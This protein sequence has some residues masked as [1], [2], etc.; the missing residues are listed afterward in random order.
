M[1]QFFG[2]PSLYLRKKQW[3]FYGMSGI[4]FCFLLLFLVFLPQL[5]AFL[6]KGIIG[7]VI[8]ILIIKIVPD[9][10]ENLS[11]KFRLRG[12]NFY[13]G[14]RGEE[15]VEKE[16]NK[17][18]S[19]YLI[20]RNVKLKKGDCDFV[21]VGPPGVFAIEVKDYKYATISFDGHDLT[22]N[23]KNKKSEIHQSKREAANIQNFL[24]TI[25][26]YVEPIVVFSEPMNLHFYFNKQNGA[27]VIGKTALI[28]L[29]TQ[30]PN[31]LTIDQINKIK[32]ILDKKIIL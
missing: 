12:D 5:A 10:L 18:D 28:D 14:R 31:Q 23:G 9:V 24:S 26:S 3:Y 17:L 1:A 20:F 8:L 6:L 4:L 7:F 22:F 13:N 32:D 30:Q 27:Y 16:L 19:N 2:K 29:I 15:E 25:V 11:E 21:V